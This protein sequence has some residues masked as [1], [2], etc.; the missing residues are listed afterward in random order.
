MRRIKPLSIALVLMF[1]L[2]PLLTACGPQKVDVTLAT[3]SLKISTNTV[4]RGKVTFHVMNTATD[5][6]HEFVIFKTDLPEDQLPLVADGT[7][8][9]E[10]GAGVTH[11][12]EVP[13]MEPGAVQ[14]LT[15]DLEP[16]N[17]VLICNMTENAIHYMRG[18]H[19]AFTV[20]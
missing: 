14:D 10:E 3:Y 18:M 13:D 9:D 4:N 7:K 6:K 11:I 12:D 15:V 8:V 16:G 1:V 19:V 2:V 5:Q 20:K 17:Y